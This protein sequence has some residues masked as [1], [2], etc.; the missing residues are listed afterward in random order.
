MCVHPSSNCTKVLG[1]SSTW[2][3]ILA[4]PMCPIQVGVSFVL[5][6]TTIIPSF[7]SLLSSV[8]LYSLKVSCTQL[9]NKHFLHCGARPREDLPTFHFVQQVLPS[10]PSSLF[11]LLHLLI[12]FFTVPS[13]HF[14]GYGW[15]AE[16]PGGREQKGFVEKATA[17]SVQI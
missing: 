8:G 15:Q 17:V 14:I 2:P 16:V 3:R 1:L 9:C 11:L 13:P 7:S 4:F 6:K 5:S 12:T 10:S